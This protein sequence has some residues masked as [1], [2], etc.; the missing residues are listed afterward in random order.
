MQERKDSLRNSVSAFMLM[1][2]DRDEVNYRRPNTSSADR[3]NNVVETLYR[4]RTGDL[5]GIETIA[6]NEECPSM[7]DGSFVFLNAY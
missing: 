2:R 7:S 1:I 6:R 4:W 3:K 5:S